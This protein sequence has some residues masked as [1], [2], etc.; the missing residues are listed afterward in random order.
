[1]SWRVSSPRSGAKVASSA[2]LGYVSGVTPRFALMVVL[3]KADKL[4]IG[5]HSNCP[6]LAGEGGHDDCRMAIRMVH[7][8]FHIING[9]ESLRD[10]LV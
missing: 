10:H 3:G 8:G 2:G 1:M 5:R 4:V 6:D 7:V 9:Q